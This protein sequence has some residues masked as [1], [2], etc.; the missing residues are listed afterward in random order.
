MTD[1][2]HHTEISRSL[3]LA[4]GH[5]AKN[6]MVVKTTGEVLV[7]HGG[8][9]K[10]FEYRDDGVIEPIAKRYRIAPFL[11]KSNFGYDVWRVGVSDKTCI[12]HV[13]KYACIALYVIEM[14]EV[15]P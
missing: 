12:E 1:H 8:L 15:R 10:R 11:K 4:I 13:C 2:E 7:L 14:R 6:I 9:C 3:A 5:P